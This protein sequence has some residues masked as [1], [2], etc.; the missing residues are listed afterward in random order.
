MDHTPQKELWLTS[1]EGASCQAELGQYHVP[2]LNQREC[3]L[4][5]GRHRNNMH[6]ARR[7]LCFNPAVHPVITNVGWTH[8]LCP[9][10]MWL[11]QQVKDWCT[12]NAALSSDLGW[13]QMSY[14]I[15]DRFLR[16]EEKQHSRVLSTNSFCDNR[17]TK[18]LGGNAP[19]L[20]RFPSAS[21]TT[22][23]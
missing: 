23:E 16:A 21:K 14:A 5:S 13:L 15:T 12:D 2:S 4:S 1:R 9:N 8:P 20:K 22:A 17:H 19:T 11:H 10:L 3:A 7:S 6:R 18:P